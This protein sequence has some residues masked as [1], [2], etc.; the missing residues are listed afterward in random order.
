[1][2][3]EA[4]LAKV[5]AELPRICARVFGD[6]ARATRCRDITAGAENHVI[7]FDLERT[8]GGDTQPLVLKLYSSGEGGAREI[9]VL[10]ALYAQSFPVP[11]VM[12]AETSREPFGRAFALMRRIEGHTLGARLREARGDD[13]A[14]WLRAFAQLAA[15]LHALDPRAFV[16]VLKSAGDHLDAELARYER[17]LREL[18]V[19]EFAPVFAWLLEQRRAL[20][21][22]GPALIHQD[23]HPL[24][25][26][27]DAAGA[28]YLLDW[29]LAHV[30]DP[31]SDLAQTFQI[32]ASNGLSALRPAITAA[33]EAASGRALADMAFFDVFAALK[34]VAGQY[35]VLD[36]GQHK[37]PALWAKLARRPRFEQRVVRLRAATGSLERTYLRIRELSGVSVPEAERLFAELRSAGT[38]S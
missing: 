13:A 16:P 17:S 21:V 5:E 23:Y 27:V 30:T 2:Y 3:A 25:V 8:D 12:H 14:P 9:E 31:R 18:E 38:A 24:N 26:V 29:S 37:R 36:H 19:P 28:L 1:V 6:G 33:Y 7:A 4:M 32:L 34:N 20:P 10:G 11:E 15:R 35:A 22:W